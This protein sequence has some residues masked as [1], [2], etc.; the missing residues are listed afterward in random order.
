MGLPAGRGTTLAGVKPSHEPTIEG[1]RVAPFSLRRS[2]VAVLPFIAP[3]GHEELRL[4][5]IEV[6]D[7]LREQLARY[8]AMQAILINSDFL[9]QAPPHALELVCRELGVGYIITGKC[10]WF[11]P[12]HSLYVEMSDTR[13]WHV[14]WANFYGGRARAAVD[15]AGEL[16]ADM[17]DSLRRVV[18]EYPPR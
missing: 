16:M 4:L 15:P 11:E 1:P 17:A 6:A 7:V 13:D 2:L 9:T 8:P 10:H 5:G 12:D 3:A 18:A 14:R